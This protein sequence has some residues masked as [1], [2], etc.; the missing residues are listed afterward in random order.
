MRTA[1]DLIDAVRLQKFSKSTC[2][3]LLLVY[4]LISPRKRSDELTSK[5]AAMIISY[6]LRRSKNLNPVLE[7]IG[8]NNSTPIQRILEG[9]EV[10][11]VVYCIDDIL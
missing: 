9:R 4:F 5:V 10:A 7:S 8:N 2:I 11:K 3:K 1:L 6:Y